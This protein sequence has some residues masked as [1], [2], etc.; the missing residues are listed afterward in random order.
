MIPLTVFSS[1][2]AGLIKTRSANGLIFM[3]SYNLKFILFI[4][5]L[6]SLSDSRQLPCEYCAKTKTAVQD[7]HFFGFVR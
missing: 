2:A 3:T 4:S 5:I 1:A 7:C 6:A